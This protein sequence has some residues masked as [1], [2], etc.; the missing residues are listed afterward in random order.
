M[1]LALLYLVPFSLKPP[2]AVVL[3]IL[4]VQ[5]SWILYKV[6]LVNSSGV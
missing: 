1:S 3:N 6:T 5:E 2:N 4:F